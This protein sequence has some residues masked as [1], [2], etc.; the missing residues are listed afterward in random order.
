M[1]DTLNPLG[2]DTPSTIDP[3]QQLTQQLTQMREDLDASNKRLEELTERQKTTNAFLQS[4]V[5]NKI[6]PNP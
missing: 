3:W 6:N 4:I 5:V 1:T 2:L